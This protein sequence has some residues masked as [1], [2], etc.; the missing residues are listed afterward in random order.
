MKEKSKLVKVILG[1]IIMFTLFSKEIKKEKD[2]LKEILS[3]LK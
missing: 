2:E 3:Y 1:R